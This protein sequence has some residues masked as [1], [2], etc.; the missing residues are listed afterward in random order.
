MKA[1]DICSLLHQSVTKNQMTK[2]YVVTENVQLRHKQM[3]CHSLKLL[4][5]SSC[6]RKQYGTMHVVSGM[7]AL[8]TNGRME[9]VAHLD[10]Q[11]HCMQQVYH[12]VV[13]CN[14]CGASGG[15]QAGGAHRLVI[16]RLQ[17]RGLGVSRLWWCSGWW[18]SGWWRTGWWCTSWQYTGW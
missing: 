2:I 10:E 17:G 11:H 18:C 6:L 12:S 1:N 5:H 8:S 3:M 7:S 4:M 15:V 13:V 9:K 14:V 16:A